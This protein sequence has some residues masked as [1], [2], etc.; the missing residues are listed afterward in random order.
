MAR[1]IE[2]GTP[3]PRQSRTQLSQQTGNGVTESGIFYRM[4][5]HC[6]ARDSRRLG[7]CSV[8]GSAVC[9][10]CGN[11]QLTRGV[12]YATHNSCLRKSA[13]GFRMIK[14]VG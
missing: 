12:R 5:P 10:N 13:D 4:C 9:E 8:C 7:E 11:L 2:A 6:G 1:S 14:F 3:A